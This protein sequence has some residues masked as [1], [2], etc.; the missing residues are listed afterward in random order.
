MFIGRKLCR[1]DVL[2][3]KTNYPGAFTKWWESTHR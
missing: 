3:F 2:G 1:M